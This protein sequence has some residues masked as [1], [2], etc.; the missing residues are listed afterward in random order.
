MKSRYIFWGM[1]SMSVML[2]G[3]SSIL[4]AN[5][6]VIE[7]KNSTKE[8]SHMEETVS[9]TPE[10]EALL[11]KISIDEERVK[12]GL[13]FSWQKE[14]LKQYDFAMEYLENKYPSYTF[15]IANCE[16]K[17]KLNNAYSLF[18]FYESGDSETYYDLYLYIEDGVYSA[19]DNFYGYVIGKKYEDKLRDMLIQAGIPCD[20]V[21]TRL[22][23]VQGEAFHENMNV[24]DIINGSIEMQQDTSLYF[25]ENSLLNQ[26][27][28]EIFDKIQEV[29]S[30][31]RIYGSYTVVIVEGSGSDQVVFEED[32]NVFN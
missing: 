13:L 31:K 24:D 20:H 18:Y 16:P 3:C 28:T 8:E 17:N 22:N 7:E 30:Q 23:T 19:E 9:M 5:N 12:E 2:T 14:I 10:Q 1:M 11:C 25:I 27:Y 6:A 29:I 21:T 32:F 4:Q 15:H 26:S